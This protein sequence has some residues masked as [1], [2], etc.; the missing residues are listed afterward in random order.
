MTPEEIQALPL[1]RDLITEGFYIDLKGKIAILTNST[2]HTVRYPLKNALRQING[3]WW[4]NV[5]LF[6]RDD[7]LWAYDNI[8][9]NQA[10]WRYY[11]DPNWKETFGNPE[12]KQIVEA[13]DPVI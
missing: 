8:Y 3:S 11:E 12:W 10:D 9:P 7:G 1:V 2:G 13:F 6:Q 5:Y 4:V